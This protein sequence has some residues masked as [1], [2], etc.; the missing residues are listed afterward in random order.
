MDREFL[1]QF[2]ALLVQHIAVRDRL[3][4]ELHDNA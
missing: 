2:E 1:H 4:S 3:R